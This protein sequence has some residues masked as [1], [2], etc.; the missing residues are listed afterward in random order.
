MDAERAGER[1][2]RA[3]LIVLTGGYGGTMEAASRGAVQAGGRV[4]GVTAADLF[5]DRAGANPHVTHEIAA[6]GITERIGILTDLARGAL[7]LPGSVG[8]IAELVIAWNINH[9]ARLNRGTRLPTV[10]VGD[11]WR[12]FRNLLTGRME[13]NG[14]DIHI[15]DTADEALDWLLAQPELG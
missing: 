8:T 12:D 5:P 3:G 13:A 4:V 1:C 10:A 11:D 9:I 7:V 15:A 14:E 2:A 6:R